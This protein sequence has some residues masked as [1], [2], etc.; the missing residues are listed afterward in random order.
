MAREATRFLAELEEEGLV[1]EADGADG[2]TPDLGSA[3]S[4][5]ASP[6]LE[7]YTDLQDLIMLDPIHEVEPKG[8]PAPRES[9]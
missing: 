4:D 3:S 6:H 7:K 5:F 1:V 9:G 2:T 8:W